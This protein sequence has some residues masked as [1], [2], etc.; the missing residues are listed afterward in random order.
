MM[1]VYIYMHKILTDHQRSMPTSSLYPNTVMT[2]ESSSI[3][4]L[5]LSNI[6]WL[7]SNFYSFGCLVSITL[8]IF[9]DTLQ[10]FF[11]DITCY[12]KLIYFSAGW[13]NWTQKM[14]L[15]TSLHS[16]PDLPELSVDKPDTQQ[17]WGRSVSELPG[18]TSVTI[19]PCADMSHW[20]TTYQLTHL[21]SQ[22]FSL[23]FF[24]WLYKVWG[25]SHRE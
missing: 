2:L 18:E 22:L 16:H 6:V 5:F 14:C 9:P 15:I 13:I 8:N 4:Y 10:E 24:L 1:Y 7:L 23:C 12:W 20:P 19:Q 17:G 3:I 21:K 25:S 11:T